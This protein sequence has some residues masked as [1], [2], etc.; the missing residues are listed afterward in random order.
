MFDEALF[1]LLEGIK[2]LFPKAIIFEEEASSI[3]VLHAYK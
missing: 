1:L 3:Y 2:T